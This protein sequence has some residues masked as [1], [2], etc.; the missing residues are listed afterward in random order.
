MRSLAVRLTLLELRERA[1]LE[2]YRRI[3][4]AISSAWTRC[5]KG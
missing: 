1:W 5:S 3:W 2:G 4:R